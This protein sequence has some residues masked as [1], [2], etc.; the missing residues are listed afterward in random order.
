M[1]ARVEGMAG[2]AV[3][4]APVAQ[5]VKVRQRSRAYWIAGLALGLVA[6]VVMAAVVVLAGLAATGE[7]P[8]VSRC[9]HRPE[10]RV[11]RSI[12]RL[13][14]ARLANQALAVRVA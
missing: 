9:L 14:V 8:A 3:K 7:R 10:A 11:R 2:L 12:S 13:E 1:T 5:A 4:A 6:P